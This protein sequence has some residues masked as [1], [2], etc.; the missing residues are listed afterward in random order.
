MAFAATMASWR[1]EISK[2][3]LWNIALT[4]EKGTQIMLLPWGD[5]DNGATL[6][7]TS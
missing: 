3:V 2:P 6:E 5:M 4:T 1:Q 7:E